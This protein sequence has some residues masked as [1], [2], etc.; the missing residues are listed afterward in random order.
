MQAFAGFGKAAGLGDGNEGIE[1]GEVHFSELRAASFKL[2]AGL[3]RDLCLRLEV[4]NAFLF[5][6]GIL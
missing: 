4:C 3:V 6:N 1:A 5:L 2:Q